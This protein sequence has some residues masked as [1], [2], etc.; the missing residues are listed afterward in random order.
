[1]ESENISP[2]SIF[3]NIIQKYKTNEVKLSQKQL[4]RIINENQQEG[5]HR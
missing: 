4:L 3:I 2:L 1:M 5:Q